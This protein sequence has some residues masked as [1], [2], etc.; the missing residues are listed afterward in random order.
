MKKL[1]KRLL[2]KKEK[3]AVKETNNEPTAT[4]SSDNNS[5]SSSC[6]KIEFYDK[7]IV[8][9]H[10]ENNTIQATIEHIYYEDYEVEEV[11]GEEKVII[12]LPRCVIEVS[13]NEEDNEEDKIRLV[14]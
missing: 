14:K 11:K 12:D 7:F 4:N 5:K 13:L 10:K 6:K 9:E 3:E 2:G 1:L 8:I